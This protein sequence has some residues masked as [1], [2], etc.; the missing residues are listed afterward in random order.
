MDS[1]FISNNFGTGLTGLNFY[2][3]SQFP[4]KI[5]KLNPLRGNNCD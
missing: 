1:Y 3:F 4:E 2:Y 5:E